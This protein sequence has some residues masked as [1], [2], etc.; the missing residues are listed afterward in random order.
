MATASRSITSE[1]TLD[2]DSLGMNK[3][4]ARTALFGTLS[5]GRGIIVL[6]SE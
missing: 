3:D 6:S 5:F 2:Q 1:D 4:R